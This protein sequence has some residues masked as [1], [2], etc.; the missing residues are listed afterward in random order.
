MWILS[1]K[2][3]CYYLGDMNV[4]F[5]K[6]GMKTSCA[7]ELYVRQ[8][9]EASTSWKYGAE[10]VWSD[11]WGLQLSCVCRK[12]C[13]YSWEVKQ[14]ITRKSLLLGKLQVK[15]PSKYSGQAFSWKFHYGV[16]LWSICNNMK[17]RLEDSSISVEK[18]YVV[19]SALDY[20]G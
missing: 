20:N 13:N 2:F 4:I 16:Y 5:E 8:S 12:F 18:W 10:M 19:E 9:F 14:E 3:K 1:Y 15:P 6:K 11:D 17:R 7:Q